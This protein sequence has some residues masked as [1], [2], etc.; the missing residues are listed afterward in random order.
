M[1]P[2]FTDPFPEFQAYIYSCL[3]NISI[4]MEGNISITRQSGPGVGHSVKSD[5][6]VTP[7]AVAH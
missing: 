1:T 4:W 3:L 6:F 7:W 2:S 5:S